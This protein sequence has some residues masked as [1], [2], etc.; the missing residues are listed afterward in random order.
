MT[1]ALSSPKSK[2]TVPVGVPAPGG[3]A[4]TLAMKVTSC[5]ATDGFGEE[6]RVTSEDTWPTVWVVVPVEGVKPVSPL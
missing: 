5:P 6:T 2:V 1:G 3:T 4:A